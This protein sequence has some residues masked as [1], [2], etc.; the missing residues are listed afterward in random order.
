MTTFEQNDHVPAAVRIDANT[1]SG[2]F[3]QWAARPGVGSDEC[4]QRFLFARVVLLADMQ[5]YPKS[6]R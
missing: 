3:V 4:I 1:G 6:N 2:C 5:S